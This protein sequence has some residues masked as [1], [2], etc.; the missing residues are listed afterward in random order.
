MFF[1]ISMA[2][3]AKLNSYTRTMRRVSD[4]VWYDLSATLTYDRKRA[5]N[6][7]ISTQVTPISIVY[8]LKNSQTSAIEESDGEIDWGELTRKQDKAKNDVSRPNIP[9]SKPETYREIP[10]AVRPRATHR[11]SIE[12]ERKRR[13][14]N[15]RNSDA[16]ILR[17]GREDNRRVPET[18]S[19]THQ[20]VDR[21]NGVSRREPETRR[22]TPRRNDRRT[23][24][25][26]RD[27]ETHGKTSMR[28]DRKR[29]RSKTRRNSS[30]AQVSEKKRM[31]E[32]KRSR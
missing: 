1:H 27:R 14:R 3:C 26:G 23:E 30:R 2:M 8:I 32:D 24:G 29:K 15:R 5:Y 28:E 9:V 13:S 31:R 6:F 17:R 20:G 16:H 18:R 7:R 19:T 4:V 11:R 22:K 10:E 25:S 12:R 21:R